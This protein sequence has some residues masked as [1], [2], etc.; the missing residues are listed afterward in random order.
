VN[1]FGLTNAGKKDEALMGL[2]ENGVL[3]KV[4]R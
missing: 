2:T 1:T 3:K 4:F